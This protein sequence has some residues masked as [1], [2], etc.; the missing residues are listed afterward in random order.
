MVLNP[1]VKEIERTVRRACFP[2]PLRL[3]GD[4]FFRQW[5]GLICGPMGG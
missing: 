4:L 5:L 1:L 3:F 2:D